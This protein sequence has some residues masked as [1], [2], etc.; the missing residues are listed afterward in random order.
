VTPVGSEAE[1]LHVD[2]TVS[3]ERSAAGSASAAGHAPGGR[4]IPRTWIRT[5]GSSVENVDDADP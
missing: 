3:L 4:S 1:R 5:S 2:V